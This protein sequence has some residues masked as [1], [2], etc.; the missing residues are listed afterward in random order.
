MD[1]HDPVL[2]NANTLIRQYTIKGLWWRERM[3]LSQLLSCSWH[4]L[5]VFNFLF[6]NEVI[7]WIN[8]TWLTSCWVKARLRFEAI[9]TESTSNP[10]WD[11][12][13][14]K[15]L[16]RDHSFMIMWHLQLCFPLTVL[17]LHFDWEIHDEKCWTQFQ[18]VLIT[19]RFDLIADLISQLFCLWSE[20]QVHQKFAASRKEV[21]FLSCFSSIYLFK[22]D[23]KHAM[24]R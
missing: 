3:T 15:A 14:N 7:V 13:A 4:C 11:S 21:H 1:L 8:N 24:C 10:Q 9:T 12:T 17:P 18:S 2:F 16:E 5:N 19:A 22:R 20:L 6:S 23:F